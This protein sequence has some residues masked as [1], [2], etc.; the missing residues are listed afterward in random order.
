MSN[1]RCPYCGK[2]QDVGDNVDCERIEN[3]IFNAIC[4]KCENEFVF[5]VQVTYDIV[6]RKADCLNGAA[7]HKYEQ[8]HTYPLF[9]ISM[10]CTVCE[11]SRD[12]VASDGVIYEKMRKEKE[13][14]L[15]S[16]HKKEKK[17]FKSL[18]ETKNMEF[19]YK[20]EP[21]L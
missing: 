8:T 9:C 15:N 17:E 7:A 5:S 2:E 16:Y 20:P 1:V 18:K 3:D 6:A 12:V 19:N 11:K 4:E 13:E 14:Y 10:R 21:D